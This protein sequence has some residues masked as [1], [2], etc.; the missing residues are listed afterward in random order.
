MCDAVVLSDG[1]HCH[2]I[3]DLRAAGFVVED[4]DLITD[5]RGE[6]AGLCSVDV[7][8][9]LNRACESEDEWGWTAEDGYW[10]AAPASDTNATNPEYAAVWLAEPPAPLVARLSTHRWDGLCPDEVEGWEVRDP[11]CK[12]CSLIDRIAAELA[13]PGR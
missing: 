2:T 6:D 10:C 9:V 13:R 12:A 7:E 11:H 4:Y 8:A 5:N 1:R 3:A